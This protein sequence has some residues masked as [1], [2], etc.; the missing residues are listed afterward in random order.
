M[1][2]IIEFVDYLDPYAF[3]KITFISFVVIEPIVEDIPIEFAVLYVEC[4]DIYEYASY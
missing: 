4:Q 2:L 3:L 1:K